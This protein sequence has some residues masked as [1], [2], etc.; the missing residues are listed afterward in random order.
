MKPEMERLVR[1]EEKV[2]HLTNLVETFFSA[3]TEKNRTFWDAREKLIVMQANARG[4]WW[5]VGLFGGLTV[6]VA[7]LVSWIVAHWKGMP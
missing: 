7:S 6:A 1:L 4:A 2:D 3:Q 5:T